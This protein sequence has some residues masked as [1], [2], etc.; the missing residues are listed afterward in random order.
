MGDAGY[1]G[2]IEKQ[3]ELGHYLRKQLIQAGFTIVNKTELPV[4]CFTHKNIANGTV[5]ISEILDSIYARK[6][7][8]ISQT[9]LGKK[10]RVLRACTTSFRTEV[11]DID[12]F[13]N[14]ISQSLK[15]PTEVKAALK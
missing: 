15:N 11:R 8:W 3:I 2:M 14:E 7:F 10:T 5:K 9:K 6:N 13:V 4:I 12:E 1:A